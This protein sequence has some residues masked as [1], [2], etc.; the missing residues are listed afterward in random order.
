MY[1]ANDWYISVLI[2][3]YFV[4]LI[5][6]FFLFFILQYG[7]PIEEFEKHMQQT[8]GLFKQCN[9]SIENEPKSFEVWNIYDYNGLILLRNPIRYEFTLIVL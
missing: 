6:C 2:V 3:K 9:W 1:F 7:H 4:I 5:L 8:R